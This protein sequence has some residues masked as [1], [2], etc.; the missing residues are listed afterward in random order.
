LIA[1]QC[2]RSGVAFLPNVC[3]S[4]RHMR[5]SSRSEK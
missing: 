3:G 4:V 5:L 2:I 1:Q